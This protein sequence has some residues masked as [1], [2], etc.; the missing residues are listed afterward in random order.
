MSHVDSNI[1]FSVPSDNN[2]KYGKIKKM[3]ITRGKIQKNIGMTINYSLPGKVILSMVKYIGMML[4]N[5]TEDM[6]EESAITAVHHLFDMVEDATKI[7]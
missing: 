5:I 1:I 6:M 3:T 7:S 2:T 4:N